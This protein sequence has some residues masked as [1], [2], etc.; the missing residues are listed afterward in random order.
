MSAIAIPQLEDSISV[1]A[2]LQL[3]KEMLLRNC[4]AAILRLQFLQQSTTSSLQLE[5]ETATIFQI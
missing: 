5:D 2:I 4:D 1:I 3:F